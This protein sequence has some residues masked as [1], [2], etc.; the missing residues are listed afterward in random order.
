MENEIIKGVH[1]R[2]I[3]HLPKLTF[4]NIFNNYFN[5]TWHENR[6][7]DG[8]NQWLEICFMFYKYLL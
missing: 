5:Y 2:C 4:S 7:L 1:N 8:K 3:W 6:P